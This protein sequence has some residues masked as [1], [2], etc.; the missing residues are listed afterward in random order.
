MFKLAVILLSLLLQSCSNY[1]SR[2][3][4]DATGYFSDAASCFRYS[5]RKVYV[6][7]P[8][9]LTMT[10]IEVPIGN[11]ANIFGLCMEHAGHA[12]PKADPD[13]YLNVSRACM[14]ETRNSSKPDDAYAKCV[15]YGKI[16]VETI[17][18]DKPK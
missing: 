16:I 5:E 4:A 18:T 10:V 8:T 9:A 6:K 13:D 2:R 1:P 12:V 3:D 14:Q 11:D 17:T 7:V 15:R